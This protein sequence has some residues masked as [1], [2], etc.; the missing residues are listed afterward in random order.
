MLV[1]AAL[2]SEQS[3]GTRV[4]LY[5]YRSIETLHAASRTWAQAMWASLG[6][7]AGVAILDVMALQTIMLV[8]P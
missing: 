8:C 5:F 7:G 2:V 3:E 6:L 1:L 4:L